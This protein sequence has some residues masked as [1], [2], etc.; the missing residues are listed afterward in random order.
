MRVRVLMFVSMGGVD[1]VDRVG[2]VLV[3]LQV[4]D[5]VKLVLHMERIGREKRVKGHP[6]RQHNNQQQRSNNGRERGRSRSTTTSRNRLNAT[7]QEDE[8]QRIG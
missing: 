2:V 3:Q 4:I 7:E 1:I 6:T 5:R 8:I